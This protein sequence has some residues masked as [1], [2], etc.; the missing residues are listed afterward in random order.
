M[1]AKS[2]EVVGPLPQGRHPQRKLAQAVKQVPPEAAVFDTCL[3]RLVGGRYQPKI[4]MLFLAGPQRAE[5]TTFQHPEQFRLQCHGH[6][7]DFIQEQS[8]AV[9]LRQKPL[10]VLVGA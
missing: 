8:A 6:V 1:T 5:L 2:F 9:G 4:R 7:T 3:Q 10:L